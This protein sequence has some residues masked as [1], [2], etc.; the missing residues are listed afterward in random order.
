MVL[1]KEH[2]TPEQIKDYVGKVHA[3]GGKV[4]EQYESLKGFSAHLPDSFAQ[5][6]QGDDIIDCVEPDRVV[7][8][9]QQ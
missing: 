8:T 4:T 7:T 1:F 6:L 2:A 5:S 3:Q 9:T